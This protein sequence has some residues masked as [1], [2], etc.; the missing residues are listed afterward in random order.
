MPTEITKD[1]IVYNLSELAQILGV[2]RITIQRYI[3]AG[4]LRGTKIG[5]RYLVSEENLKN[6][7]NNKDEGIRSYMNRRLSVGIH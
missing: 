7:V 1:L 6:F 5:R 3:N 2:N 4:R